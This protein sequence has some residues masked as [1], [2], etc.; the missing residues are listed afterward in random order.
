MQLTG[1]SKGSTARTFWYLMDF[2]A[3]DH[4]LWWVGENLVDAAIVPSL[5]TGISEVPFFVRLHRTTC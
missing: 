2:L 1:H 3:K 4:P 5:V